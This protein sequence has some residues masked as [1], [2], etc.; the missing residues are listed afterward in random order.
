[1]GNT[2]SLTQGVERAPLPIRSSGVPLLS[3]LVASSD[4]FLKV[5][6]LLYSLLPR[7]QAQ[8]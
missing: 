6:L 4:L 8:S 5:E 1:M 7:Q 3:V 2:P